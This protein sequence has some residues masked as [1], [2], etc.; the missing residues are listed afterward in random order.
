VYASVRSRFGEQFPAMS[1]AYDP[2]LRLLAN[3]V[4]EELNM[5]SF[6]R[7]G[8]Y[9][10]V[11]GPFFETIAECRMARWLGGDVIGAYASPSSYHS[12]NVHIVSFL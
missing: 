8:V 4:A 12:E 11:S 3:Q 9:F 7:D 6:V 1:T 5:K 10:C 2:Q